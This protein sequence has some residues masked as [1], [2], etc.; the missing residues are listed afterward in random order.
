MS[1]V[2]KG[3]SSVFLKEEV[4]EGQ[5]NP[6]VNSDDAIEVLEDFAGFEYTRDTIE[7]TVLSSTIESDAPRS[8]LP[9]VTS[10]LPTEFKASAVEGEAPRSDVLLKSLLGGKRQVIDPIVLESGSTTTEL[11]LND[12]DANKLNKGDSVHVKIAGAHSIRPV[13]SVDNTLGAVKV[14]LAIPLPSAPAAGVEVAPLTT[15][16]FEENDS[17]FSVAAEMGGEITEQASGCKVESA[18]ISNWTTGQ[19]PQI[20]F[21]LKALSLNKVDAVSGITPDF[22][23]EPQPPVALDACAYIDGE[24]VDYNEFGLT[25]ANSINDVLSACSSQGKI[26]SRNTKLLVT[27][28]INP[29]MKGDDVTRFEKFN[30]STP[31]SLFIHISNPSEVAGEF[32][33]AAAIFMPKVTLTSITNGDQEGV[34]TDELEFQASKQTANDTIFMS[35]I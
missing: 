27:G 31:V 17:S 3:R 21:G 24:E 6:P 11:K 16:F 20:A 32:K 23:G 25:V 10:S 4:T 1:F 33:N 18:E 14:T 26:A 13:A 22:S 30:N 28:S 12:L 5:Y 7:R 9:N 19:I 35:F 34:L 15:Y 8:G 29:Y 2:I